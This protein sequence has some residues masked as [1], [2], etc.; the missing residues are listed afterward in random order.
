MSGAGGVQNSGTD[1][2]RPHGQ[3]ADIGELQFRGIQHVQ[4]D[5][6]DQ[7]RGL[8]VQGNTTKVDVVVGLLA[9]R[10]GDLATDD[11]K[12]LDQFF[13]SLAGAGFAH[14]LDSSRPVG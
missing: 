5:L 10:E 1:R 12:F 14:G 7:P 6:P 4:H 8:V 11:G 2:V 9:G 3:A 13:K